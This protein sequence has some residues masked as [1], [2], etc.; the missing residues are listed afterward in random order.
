MAH[1]AARRSLVEI[2]LP[3]KPR[4]Y[5]PGDGPA[6]APVRLCL[7]NDT[8]AFI[9]DKRVRPGKPVNGELKLELYYVVGWPDLPAARVAILATKVLDYVSPRTLEDWEYKRSLEKD[10]EQEKQNAAQKRKQEERAKA[11][12]GSTPGAGTSTP[13]TA[14][15]GQKR[16]GRPSKA[17]MLARH[18]AKQASFG[19]NE[20]ANV[21]LP[22]TSTDGPSLSTPKKKKLVQVVTDVEELEETDTNDAIAKQLRGGS[23]SDSESQV[24]EDLE[25]LNES[26]D[27]N[28]G[29]VFTSLEPFQPAHS[30]RGYA[31]FF[32]LNLPLSTHQDPIR[33]D[34]YAPIPLRPHSRTQLSRRKTQ[35]TT[36]VP[37]PP[38]PRQGRK[39]PPTPSEISVTPV[40]A[41]SIPLLRPKLPKLPHV[42][43]YTPVPAPRCPA[44]KPKP[45]KAPHEP[46]CTPVPAPVC[47]KLPPKVPHEPTFTPVPLPSYPPPV[48]KSFKNSLPKEPHQVTCTPV[49]P[50]LLGPSKKHEI[51]YAPTRTSPPS[52][53]NGNTGSR[54]GNSFTPAGRSHRKQSTRAKAEIG[55]N[56]ERQTPDSASPSKKTSNFRKK[57]QPQPQEEQVW[58]VRRLED[59]KIIE[60]GGK[61]VRYFKVRWVGQWPPDQ[62]PTWEPEE[63]IADALIRK[64]LKDKAAKFARNG[65]SP[66]R[67]EMPTPT[68][69]RKYSSVAEAFEGD[70]NDPPTHSDNLLSN[71]QLEDDDDG[72]DEELFKVTEQTRSNTPFWKPR[73][74]PALIAELAASFSLS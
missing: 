8:G 25:E 73:L 39:K 7:E 24:D 18:I 44:P 13:G 61:L 4:D 5:R 62:N 40:P 50:P 10:E 19:D 41:P 30:S 11:R 23:E 34:P 29:I 71:L 22:P 45:P 54:S 53:S 74:D 6:L 70:A 31:E 55:R 28:S 38:Y 69:K 43:T 16:R 42:V 20:L 2:P 12:A 1:T 26:S 32:V 49:P 60:T 68:L 67:I 65:S 3:S 52:S 21:P 63:Y 36:L 59:D 14:T 57:K 33:F 64:Y 46:K 51:T 66:R 47:P 35:L 17:E 9:V 48:Q 58:E 15:P 56:N 72:D 37:V 27:P